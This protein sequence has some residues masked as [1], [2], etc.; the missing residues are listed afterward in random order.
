MIFILM[1]EM[2]EIDS[3]RE[4]GHYKLYSTLP[5]SGHI[6]GEKV[7]KGPSMARGIDML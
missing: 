2:S 4:Y 1:I 7:Y 3:S 5:Q 6:K